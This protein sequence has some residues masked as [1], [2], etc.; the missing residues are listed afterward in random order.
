[1]TTYVVLLRAIGPATHKLMSMSQWRDAAEAAGFANPRTYVA[2]GNMI[3]E[4]DLSAVAVRRR[5]EEIVRDFGL[6]SAVIVR[7]GKMLA[8]LVRA[9]PFPEA[10]AERP[11]EVGVYFFAS[12]RP[13]LGW[14]ADYDGSEP[15]HVEG[16]HL[17]VDYSGKPVQSLRLP[18][19]IERRSG[20]VTARNWNTL[21]GLAE[22]AEQHSKT[23][24]GSDD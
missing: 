3:L 5:T 21:R 23:H 12:G 10:I 1:M 15:I 16:A 20:V 4:S 8:K 2:T 17:M 9:A 14:V 6:T 7:T 13:D 18:G 22:R 11:G 24:A 19:L